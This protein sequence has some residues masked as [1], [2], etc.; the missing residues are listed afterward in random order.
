MSNIYFMA[1]L[2][3]V[4]KIH[5]GNAMN[6][7][8]CQKAPMVS[9]LTI[10][11]LK[12]IKWVFRKY[13]STKIPGMVYQGLLSPQGLKGKKLYFPIKFCVFQYTNSTCVHNNMFCD[14]II[15]FSFILCNNIEKR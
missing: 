5:I 13:M 12:K 11:I 15:I 6:R 4:V 9:V 2:V 1:I 14:C 8:P 10:L 7:P 3:D